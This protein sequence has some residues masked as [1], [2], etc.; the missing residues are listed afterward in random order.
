M[1]RWSFRLLSKQ[2]QVHCCF[3]ST[4]TIGLLGT[5]TATSTSTQ[6]LSSDITNQTLRKFTDVTRSP[7]FYFKPTPPPPPKK[8]EKKKKKKKKSTCLTVFHICYL[9]ITLKSMHIKISNLTKRT[10]L[11]FVQAYSFKKQKSETRMTAS[12][13]KQ[14]PNT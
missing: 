14:D 8:K 11:R 2:F 7:T 9:K 13:L 3:T 4:E 1:A 12:V 10:C 6:L 5:R